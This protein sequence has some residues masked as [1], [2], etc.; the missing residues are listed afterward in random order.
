ML[1][2]SAWEPAPLL[3]RFRGRERRRVSRPIWF[4]WYVADWKR[5]WE[6]R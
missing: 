1:E 2:P 4:L 3:L 6:Y 5:V